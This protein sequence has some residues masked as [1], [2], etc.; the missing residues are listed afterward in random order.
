VLVLVEALARTDDHA[1]GVLA[2]AA[3]FAD[4]VGHGKL[5]AVDSTTFANA[6]LVPRGGGSFSQ[7]I[8]GQVR[9]ALGEK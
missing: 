9:A 4:D 1:I 6:N 7:Q 3:R 2:I 5:L 8:P